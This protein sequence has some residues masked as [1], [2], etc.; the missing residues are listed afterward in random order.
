M[1]LDHRFTETITVAPLTGSRDANGDPS[2]GAQSTMPARVNRETITVRTVDG[3]LVESQTNLCTPTAIG[4]HDRV[5][6]PEAD[7]AQ[8]GA[9]LTPVAVKT[10]KTLDGKVVMF[11]TYF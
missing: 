4:K 3:T 1:N 10:V 7:T 2:Y 5:W 11:R 6:L 8:A 9:A